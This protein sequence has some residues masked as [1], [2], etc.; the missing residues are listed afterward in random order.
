MN[1][2]ILILSS[3]PAPYRVDVFKGLATEFDIDVFF[4]TDKDQ[5]RSQKWFSS[6]EGFRYFV[7]TDENDLQYY[8][9]CVKNLKQYDL[10]LA[11]DW[12]LPFSLKVMYKC[13][14]NKIPYIVNCDGAFINERVNIKEKAKDF[15][16]KFFISRANKCFASGENAAK[17]FIHYGAKEE[18]IIIHNFSSLYEEDILQKPLLKQEKREQKKSLGLDERKTVLS[19][20]QFIPR[21]G[22]DILLEAWEKLDN[23]YQ[24]VIIGGGYEEEKYKKIISDKEFKH[25]KLEGF[26]SKVSLFEYYQAA[27]IFIL[28]TREDIWGLVINEAMA[29]GLPIITTDKCIAGLE[30]IQDGQNGF[31]VKTESASEIYEKISFLLSND[32]LE[33]KISKANL[34]K[35]KGK[36]ISN[37]WKKHIESINKII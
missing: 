17:Y 3:F 20:G 28:P 5:S 18:N 34:V 25:V 30:L 21:K 7:L 9:K 11:Y 6:K 36:T 23:D 4:N 31:V 27:D 32:Y 33:N 1:K 12:Y 16:K 15:V 19:I 24:L 29:C 22:I 8:K 14:I 37:I 2:R 35:I 26:K 13:I 10:V